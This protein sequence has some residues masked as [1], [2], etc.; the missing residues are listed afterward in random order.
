[1]SNYSTIRDFQVPPGFKLPVLQ[2][3]NYTDGQIDALVTQFQCCYADRITKYMNALKQGKDCCGLD[4]RTKYLLL[5]CYTLRNWYNPSTLPSSVS[6]QL[7]SAS[8][9][10]STIN[11]YVVSSNGSTSTS[12]PIGSIFVNVF[13]YNVAVFTPSMSTGFTATLVTANPNQISISCTSNLSGWIYYVYEGTP[14]WVQFGGGI[15]TPCLSVSDVQKIIENCLKICNCTSCLSV[16]AMETD[17][18]YQPVGQ[19]PLPIIPTP[20]LLTAPNIYWN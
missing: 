20:L 7:H 18:T 13:N 6:F 2:S 10:E 16:A 5:S 17:Q 11:F 14:N 19:P 15:F 4:C 12:S 1:M 8:P 9:N 3:N